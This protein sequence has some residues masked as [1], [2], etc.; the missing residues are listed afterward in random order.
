MIY[1]S[2]NNDIDNRNVEHKVVHG[3]VRLYML[4]KRY[5]FHDTWP[6]TDR[7]L[8]SLSLSCGSFYLMHH[9]ELRTNTF[10]LSST[11]RNQHAAFVMTRSHSGL[12]SK[13]RS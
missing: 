9:A 7:L 3:F 13:D 10:G 6:S 8:P 2:H 12:P 5:H 1:L 11:L 4:A